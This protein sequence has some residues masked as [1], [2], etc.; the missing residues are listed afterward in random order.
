[1]A[2]MKENVEAEINAA[3]DEY[4]KMDAHIRLYL[5]EIESCM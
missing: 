5:R 1:M 4:V 3:R 2:D